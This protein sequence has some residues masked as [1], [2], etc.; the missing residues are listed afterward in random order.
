MQD[1]RY[2]TVTALTKYLKYKFDNDFNLTNVLL[3]GEISN[4]KLNSKGH[5][6][7]TLKDEGAEI[8]ALMFSSSARLVNFMPKDGDKVL[9]KGRVT[10]Y[11][12]SGSYQIYVTSMKMQGLGELYVKYEKLK[13]ELESIG[14][15]DQSHKK[16]IP[17]IPKTIGVITS[18]TGA[19]IHDI[20]TTISRRYPL[21]KVILYPSLVQGIEAK[22][23]IASQIKKANQDKLCDVLIVGRGGGSIEDL[24][25]FNERVVAD[26]IY[27][28]DI[29]IISAVGHEVDFTIADFVA[30][31]R[32]ATPTA[33]AECAT[34][35]LEALKDLINEYKIRM[36]RQVKM[37]I[38][39]KEIN[40]LNL[41]NRLDINNPINKLRDKKKNVID[42]RERLNNNINYIL[43]MKKN[44]FNLYVEKLKALSPINIMD[45]GY[46]IIHNE[47]NKLINSISYIKK[48]DN[49][50]LSFK[51][52]YAK[53]QIL[54]VNDGK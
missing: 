52:G 42:L 25:A 14:Y 6:Y 16:P 5:F 29:P 21:C 27:L 2:V 40:L 30:D 12:A 50:K 7:F 26:Q 17:S 31:M 35:S 48:D 47:D 37:R 13:R 41:D 18:P 19:A 51:D 32:A 3:E 8:K 43:N 10:I 46:T 38:K 23:S 22:D 34:P 53:A 33:A 45:K 39:D 20:I 54:E 36:T 15:F 9:V 4:F 49:I 1:D 11:E 28:S 24:W 44:M